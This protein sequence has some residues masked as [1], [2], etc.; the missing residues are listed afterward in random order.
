MDSVVLKQN[1]KNGCVN[2][3]LTV[4]RIEHVINFAFIRRC[5]KASQLKCVQQT[6][7]KYLTDNHLSQQQK[8]LK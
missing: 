1:F 5:I 7:L 4:L 3:E 6:V 2:K 8:Q